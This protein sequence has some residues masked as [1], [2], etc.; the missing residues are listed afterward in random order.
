MCEVALPPFSGLETGV[1]ELV[2]KGAGERIEGKD[3]I[4]K[5]CIVEACCLSLASGAHE[6]VANDPVLVEVGSGDD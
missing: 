6:V 4:L 5:G 1:A 2:G 3:A